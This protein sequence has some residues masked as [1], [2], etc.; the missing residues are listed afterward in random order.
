MYGLTDNSARTFVPPKAATWSK[1]HETATSIGGAGAVVCVSIFYPN[2]LKYTD[3]DGRDIFDSSMTED[4]FN[5]NLFNLPP[6]YRT[7]NAV[8]NFFSDYPNGAFSAHDSELRLSAYSDKKDIEYINPDKAN[9]EFAGALFGLKAISIAAPGIKDALTSTQSTISRQAV[10][11]TGKLLTLGVSGQAS[12][13]VSSLEAL[14]K[15]E[16]GRN[17][18]RQINDFAS[19]IAPLVQDNKAQT[20]LLNIQDIARIFGE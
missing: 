4:D 20:A 17:L 11:E 2:P 6:R 12:K 14:S 8:Q 10:I 13:I 7:W 5:D 18:I 1:T 15:T 3:P 16:V 19:R 9:V